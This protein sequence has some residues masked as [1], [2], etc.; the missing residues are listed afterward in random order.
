MSEFSIWS[1]VK[2]MVESNDRLRARVAELEAAGDRLENAAA[3][4]ALD[5]RDG[6]LDDALIDWRAVR[7][8]IASGER[9]EGSE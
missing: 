1:E 3:W 5:V 9:R 8:T 2:R 7:G 4:T 6:A